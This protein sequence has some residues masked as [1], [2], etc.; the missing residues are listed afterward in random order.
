MVNRAHVI[1]LIPICF[2]LVFLLAPIVFLTSILA[3]DPVASVRYLNVKI[4]PEGELFRV[5]ELPES[6]IV[7]F[8]GFDFGP[9]ANT[10]LLGVL[11][12]L[13]TTSLALFSVVACLGT[14]G[15]LRLLIGYVLPLL[16]SLPAPFI[17]AYA[18]THLFHREF[19]ILSKAIEQ[20]VGFRVAFEG[21][22]GVLVYQVLSL[23]PLSHLVLMTYIDL[24][25]RNMLDAASNLGA[26]GLRVIRSV[27]VPLSRPALIVSWTLT[28]VLSCED[29]SG[30]VAFSRYNSARNLMAYIAYYDFVSEYG[31]TVSLRSIVYVVVLLLLASAVFAVFWKNLKAYRYPVASTRAAVVEMGAS[32]IAV[33]SVAI[34]L[35]IL[36]LLPKAMVI[37]YSLTDGWYGY[38]A[39]RGLT[40]SNY[41]D[42]FVTPYYLRSLA[43][44]VV[45]S[46]IS[47]LLI[48]FIA[49]LATYASLRLET[50]LSLLVEVLTA[51]P[52]VIPGIAVGIGYFTTFH[53]VFK[54]L[55]LLDPLMNPA[56]YIV[57]A[58]AARRL[59]YATKPLSAAL[60]KVSKSM[61]EQA[62][63][64]G[65]GHGLVIRTVTLPL[66]S[67]AF[68]VAAVLVS[69]Y[70]STEF[71]VSLVLAGGYG[72][73][74]S[75]PAPVI[76][77]IV[78][79]MIYNPASIHVASALLITTVVLSA[80]VSAV[81]A[82]L[83]LRLVS[84]LKWRPF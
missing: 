39:P 21:I 51:L 5:Y 28:F 67:N 32:G 9:T 64:L 10:L 4:P 48:M 55:P 53:E 45:Y 38:V 18:V 35:Q 70:A 20:L 30:P 80:T 50:A 81:L 40:L 61:E 65:A 71:S 59:T 2:I 52:I 11:S 47:V 43:N 34:A 77:V 8:T 12:S 72:V 16:A 58:Y 33:V 19:G 66:A 82:I 79:M 75:H 31:F 74:A 41:V 27:V 36:S 69:I 76:P 14:R 49:S 44:T 56:P 62:L 57:I 13:I 83:I 6:K 15:K 17:S 78:N 63:N 68:I 37:A 7:V 26:R 60:Q 25:D 29:L 73:S 54:N 84:G 46:T 24:V 3:R 1:A 22:S 23:Y 42:A